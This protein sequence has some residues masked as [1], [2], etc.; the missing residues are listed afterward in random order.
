MVS[1]SIEF[2]ILLLQKIAFR[3]SNNSLEKRIG[4]CRKIEVTS[5]FIAHIR[6]SVLAALFGC[7]EMIKF[8]WHL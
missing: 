3:R 4:V 5:K 2:I 1:M 8:N 6:D 7:N